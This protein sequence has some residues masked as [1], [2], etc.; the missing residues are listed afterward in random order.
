MRVQP[1]GIFPA[2]CMMT[3][4]VGMVNHVLIVPLILSAAYRDAWM[5][6]FVTLIV[7]LPWIAVPFYGLLAKLNG[8]RLDRWMSSRLPKLIKWVI[9]GFFMACLF[10]TVTETLILTSSW[11][12]TT[13]LNNTPPVAVLMLFVAISVYAACLGLR[14]IGYL[15]CILL[16]IVVLVG[17]FV[18]SANLPHKDY[19]YLLPMLE[20]G[21]SPVLAASV[22]SITAFGEFFILIM[23]QHHLKGRFKRW[24]LIVLT[25][26]LA[27][28]SIGPVSGAISEFGPIEA[29]KM[30]YP[31]FSQWRLVTIGRYF[32]HVDFFAIYQWL[33]GALVRM[34]VGLY[35]LVEYSSIGRMRLRWIGIVSLSAVVAGIGWYWIDHMVDYK[36]VLHYTYSYIGIGTV[37]AVL[38]LYM[39]AWIKE[40]KGKRHEAERA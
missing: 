35:L 30:R 24:H 16:P 33:S 4:S 12:S 2:L 21:I 7:I 32:E 8:Q 40:R 20:N 38:V 17:D 15:S 31:A 28:L 19:R 14:T 25:L 5:S 1:F 22:Y 18:M 10:L 26:F 23:L 37:S 39:A 9:M 29:E 27:L 3:L 6:T 13:Y 34:S 11:T 36:Y